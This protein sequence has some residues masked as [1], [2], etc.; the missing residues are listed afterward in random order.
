MRKAYKVGLF[1]NRTLQAI[2]KS[3]FIQPG[4][5]RVIVLPTN[6]AS[7]Y[8]WGIQGDAGRI[9]VADWFHTSIHAELVQNRYK[10]NE[11]NTLMENSGVTFQ[12]VFKTIFDYRGDG[13]VK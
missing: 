1:Y 3:Y 4:T 9:L 5:K 2:I 11:K 7:F 10:W 13:P 8:S 12:V 6:M